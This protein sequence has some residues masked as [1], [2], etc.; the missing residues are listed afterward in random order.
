MTARIF[1]RTRKQKNCPPMNSFAALCNHRIGMRIKLPVALLVPLLQRTPALRVIAAAEERVAASP[2]GAVLK[3]VFS[4]VASLGAI[5]SL[6]GATT[7]VASVPSPV[8]VTTGREI[9]PIAFTVTDTINIG[10]WRLGGNLPPGL[11]LRAQNG[12]ELSDPG[13]LDATTP[14]S[15]DGYG[16]IT[17]G[18]AA[19]IPLLVGTP[20]QAGTYTI[21]LQAL[22]PPGLL[23]L[24]SSVFNYTITVT[25]AAVAA[26]APTFTTQ[27]AA[28]SGTVGGTLT[29]TAAASGS[30]SPTFQW[31]KGGTAI[32]GAT[33]ATLTLTNAQLADAGSYTV[34]ATNSAGTATSNAVT[35]TVVG[36]AVSNLVPS[37]ARQP[38]AQT[39]ATGSTVVYTADVTGSPV[40]AYQW[41]KNTA[42]ISGA[43][44]AS[45]VIAAA[46]AADAGSYSVV[47][48]NASGS[49]TSA[50]A[51][52]ELS[53]D[54][55]F[56]HLV[57][58]SIRTSLTASDPTFTVG[59]VIGGAGT[60]G[61]KPLLV[62]AVGPSLAA[63]GITTALA[64][65][66]VDVFSAGVVVASNDNWS[67]DATL[68]AAFGRVGAFP[69]ASATSKDAAVFN[70]GFSAGPYTIDVGSVGGAVGEVI[71][72]LYDAT[73]TASFSAA[74]PRLVNVSVRKQIGAT[75]ILTAGFVVGG[76]TA[77]T[78]LV[79]AI[80]P[81]LAA[82]GVS[83]TIPDPQL[84]LNS[85][86]L[87]IA[88]N[89][90][91]GGDSQLT[92]AGGAV[93]AFAI[94]NAASKDAILL[95]TL[96]PGAYTAEVK[97]IGGG[98]SVLVEVYEVP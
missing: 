16:E 13:V 18:V 71:A 27:P 9:T 39:V 10:S 51:I 15:D 33:A 22:Q 46:T 19:T 69:L 83:G 14:G 42:N 34:V 61:T 54:P 8:T 72:E 53:N 77:R 12:S 98:G 28:Q 52:L 40:P 65:S 20:T 93:G 2:I 38:V 76:N 23:S 32:A 80:G 56:G 35:V 4:A 85:G 95:I 45:L 7:L 82:F 55:N 6:A 90:N 68:S 86:A 64:D 74:T 43:T 87:Q 41:R 89:D 11:K 84:T 17:G 29:L 70:P 97:G 48:T 75:E 63:F 24:T 44:R 67:G 5:H 25:G 50:P 26:T 60:S 57:N 47:A 1:D 58:L 94:A 49:V 81:G 92:A 88:V 73:A 59:T 79:R 36:S 3:A 91:W 30:P 62:R 21:T 78:V 37:V 96:A 66:K 31:Q